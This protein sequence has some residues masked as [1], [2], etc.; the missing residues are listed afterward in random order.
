MPRGPRIRLPEIPIHVIQRGINRENCFFTETDRLVYL[1]LLEHLSKH[2]ECSIHAYVLMT[3]HV[4]LLAT[5]KHETSV[6]LLMKNLGQQYVQYVNR[7]LGRS[8]ALWE[9]RYRSS[10]VASDR[11]LFICHRYIELNPVRAKLVRHPADYLWSSFRANALGQPS[12]LVT[13]HPLLEELGRTTERRC[14]AYRKLFDEEIDQ[15]T[16]EEMRDRITANHPIG[17]ESFVQALERQTGKR[18]R[19]LPPG[20]APNREPADSSVQLL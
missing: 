6:S 8:G 13:P 18:L 7:K 1:S 16:L 4:H 17:P 15:A 5:P 20:P 3:N 10:F 2:F 14:R 9:G 19:K 12:S 11:Y